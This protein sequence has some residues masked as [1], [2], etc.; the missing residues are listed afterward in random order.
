M[1]PALRILVALLLGLALGATLAEADASLGSSVMAA[2]ELIGG[3][4]INALR[5]TVIPLVLP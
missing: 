4:W 5:I 1:A 3:L 2:V